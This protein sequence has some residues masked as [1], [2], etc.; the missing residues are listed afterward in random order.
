[1]LALYLADLF[2]PV[3]AAA[4]ARPQSR[5]GRRYSVRALRDN[6]NSDIE[7]DLWPPN[8]RRP[9]RK[10]RRGRLKNTR[11]IARLKFLLATALAVVIGAA[12]LLTGNGVLPFTAAAGTTTTAEAEN[13]TWSP[14]SSV[15]VYSD[16]TASGG[17][18]VRVHANAAG[19]ASITTGSSI[20]QVSVIAY[21]EQCGGAPNLQ[22]NVDGVVLGN[23][24]VTA[25]AWTQYNFPVNVAAG[26]HIVQLGFTNQYRTRRCTRALRLDRTDV[27]L[28]AGSPSPAP[29]FVTR[30][31]NQLMLNGAP[32][33]FAGTNNY[34]LTGCDGAP[35]PASQAAAYFAQLKPNTVTRVWAFREQGFA[36]VQQTV[37]LAEK[38]SQ[39][40]I[41]TFAEGAGYCNAPKWTLNWYRGGYKTDGAYFPWIG[42]LTT[43]FKN[44]PAV[45]FWEIMNEPGS[46][47]DPSLGSWPGYLTADDMKS[48]FDT[49]AAYI[50][51]NDPNHLVSTGT[52]IQGYN[53]T[54]A[55][56]A[57]VH[58]GPYID[59]V[60]DHDYDYGNSNGSQLGSTWVAMTYQAAQ[61]INKPA[62]VG[63]FGVG[64]NNGS[65]TAAQR[66]SVAKQKFDLY[67][68]Q[69]LS[70]VLYWCT[71]G[72]N[73]NGGIVTNQV[74]NNDPMLASPVINMIAGYT[75]PNGAV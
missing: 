6:L 75:G 44:S 40:L 8:Q 3:P 32:Y 68:S 37:A 48:F 13:M 65:M 5:F 47:T 21:G 70:G 56:M 39:K 24:A 74:Y 45:A 42:Q 22:V 15:S 59:I 60:S 63:E 1:M 55:T 7:A 19:T 10:S 62:L 17:Q 54:A 71:I 36:P 35:V 49:T 72:Y 12:T 25:I 51:Q 53:Q 66:A 11:Q 41:L 46:L 20:Q 57:Y 9:I 18:A 67:L 52:N 73:N 33:R 69:G 23:Q 34:S 29:G 31:G 43:A 50:K 61:S 14:A 16:S 58:S 26:T 4:L 2:W 38:Y 28:S 64:L 30:T 27:Y